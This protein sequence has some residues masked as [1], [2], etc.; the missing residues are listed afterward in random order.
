MGIPDVS[1]KKNADF[2][3]PLVNRGFMLFRFMSIKMNLSNCIHDELKNSISNQR[4]GS[5]GRHYG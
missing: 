3:R 5:D 1:V 4:N 2:M